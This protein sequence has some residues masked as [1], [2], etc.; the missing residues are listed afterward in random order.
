MIIRLGNR[1][2][3]ACAFDSA[4]RFGANRQGV[5]RRLQRK[6]SCGLRST[7][8]RHKERQRKRARHG[9]PRSVAAAD[10]PLSAVFF[11]SLAK[12]WTHRRA[13]EESMRWLDCRFGFRRRPG[14]TLPRAREL[15]AAP[16]AETSATTQSAASPANQRGS[17][18][19][20]GEI[21]WAPPARRVA[22]VTPQA[23]WASV[24]LQAIPDATMSVVQVR[25]GRGCAPSGTPINSAGE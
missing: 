8:E 25:H 20:N 18:Q 16:R 10:D 15:P 7:D 21:G 2:L 22:L 13:F 6:T 4:R 1:F 11:R 14:R 24:W 19:A 3:P 12:R 9:A 5:L 23:G 17:R